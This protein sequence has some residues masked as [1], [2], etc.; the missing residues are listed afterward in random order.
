MKKVLFTFIVTTLLFSSVCYATG[1]PYHA[2]RES[3]LME[4][5]ELKAKTTSDI[6]A[7][8]GIENRYP[9]ANEADPLPEIPFY[10]ADL[11][12]RA[13]YPLSYADYDF[14]QDGVKELVISYGDDTF[15]HIIG[16][17]VFDGTEMR[18]LFR[19]IPLREKV[20]LLGYDPDTLQMCI[21]QSFGANDNTTFLYRLTPE[22][23]K[24]EVKS[25][26]EIQLVGEYAWFWEN[27]DY[28][29]LTEQD[30]T[31]LPIPKG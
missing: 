10:T 5:Q 18:Y 4:W 26:H 15:Q 1:N 27:L 3:M 28:F 14:N 13:Q 31:L 23:I 17:Y 2:A 16:I 20:N 11:A 8:A 19:E 29:P 22:S 12:L 30:G 21:V 6:W 7:L 9:D 24:P 25:V